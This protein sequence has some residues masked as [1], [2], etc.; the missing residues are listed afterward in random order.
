MNLVYV[1]LRNKSSLYLDQPRNIEAVGSRTLAA[2]GSTLWK[3]KNYTIVHLPTILEGLVIGIVP[4]RLQSTI[5]LAIDI[6]GKSTVYIAF[7]PGSYSNNITDWLQINNWQELESFIVY[8]GE[9]GLE[10]MS[11]IW[12][13]EFLSKEKISLT[14]DLEMGTI[15]VFIESGKLFCKNVFNKR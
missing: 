9:N 11:H 10:M 13:K 5:D 3:D 6:D 7:H 12:S 8:R 2:I 1:N 14:S 15:A 4:Y